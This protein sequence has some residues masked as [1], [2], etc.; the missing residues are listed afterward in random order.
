MDI[1]ADI[2][3]F[4]SPNIYFML[5]N[6]ETKIYTAMHRKVKIIERHIKGLKLIYLFGSVIGLFS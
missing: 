2:F 1:K 3:E 5:S 4:Y 6:D